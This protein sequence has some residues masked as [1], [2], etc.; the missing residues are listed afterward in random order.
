LT[1]VAL[2][3][4]RSIW[5]VGQEEYGNSLLDCFLKFALKGHIAILNKCAFELASNFGW[6][7]RARKWAYGFAMHFPP[8]RSTDNRSRKKQGDQNYER[9]ESFGSNELLLNLIR[10]KLGD[11]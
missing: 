2:N 5:A 11:D 9:P 7:G 4:C 1:T 8:A 6:K 10:N 3:F